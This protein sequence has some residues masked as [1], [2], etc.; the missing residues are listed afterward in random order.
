MLL[1][2]TTKGYISV[3]RDGGLVS[4]HSVETEAIESCVR[5]AAE[6]GSGK[7]TFTYPNKEVTV[8][9]PTVVP[10]ETGII[11]GNAEIA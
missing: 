1:D 3:L 4:R 10:K 6:N 11:T 2:I 9:L 5:H 8:T 7:Y